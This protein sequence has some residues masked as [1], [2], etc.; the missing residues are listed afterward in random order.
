MLKRKSETSMKDCKKHG[1]TPHFKTPNKKHTSGF[2]EKCKRCNT[3][4]V[5]RRRRQLKRL[6]VEHFGGKCQICGYNKCVGALEFHHRNPKNKLFGIATKMHCKAL[7]Q[8]IKEA[9][10]CMLLCANCHKEL[11]FNSETSIRKNSSS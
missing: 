11:H 5:I 1:V 7:K 8:L 4:S 10:K 2:R 9:E 3:E 6:L